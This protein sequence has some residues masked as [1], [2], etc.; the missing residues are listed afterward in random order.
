MDR[1][2]AYKQPTTGTEIT[3]AQR[4]EGER[5]TSRARKIREQKPKSKLN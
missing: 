5:D 3:A 2:E 4:S 1:Q